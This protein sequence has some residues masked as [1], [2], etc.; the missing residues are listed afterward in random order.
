M[1]RHDEM[2]LSRL[3]F[4]VVPS[5]NSTSRFAYWL[6]YVDA[7][8]QSTPDLSAEEY[9]FVWEDLQDIAATVAN[10]D[11]PG[12]PPSAETIGNALSVLT[13]TMGALPAPEISALENGTLLMLWY[14]RRGFMSLE[15]GASEYGF[16]ITSEGRQSIRRNG[17]TDELKDILPAPWRATSSNSLPRSS[18]SIVTE[19]GDRARDQIRATASALVLAISTFDRSVAPA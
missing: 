10:W 15:L 8:G 3:T 17:Q 18:S 11:Q 6:P 1:I 4:P 12:L 16:V 9:R 2:A 14:G 5:R 19:I 13:G 7:S